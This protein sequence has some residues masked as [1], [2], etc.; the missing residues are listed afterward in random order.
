MAASPV[1]RSPKPCYAPGTPP[2]SSSNKRHRYRHALVIAAVVVVV[3]MIAGAILVTAKW[4]FTTAKL[5]AELASAT[6][7]DVQFRSFRA[8]Y[9]PPGCVMEGVELRQ[10]P[11]PDGPPLLTAAR[12]TIRANYR[13]FLFNRIEVMRLE[14]VHVD[15][16]QRAKNSNSG[17]SSGASNSSS[18]STTV[19]E[20]I[21]DRGV[22]E[23]PRKAG[24]L[25]F[26]V[27]QLT[28]GS[29]VRG[30][31]TSFHVTLENPL[32]P[33]HLA[34]D[35]QFGPW[36]SSNVGA[37]PLSGKYRFTDAQ[38]SSLG[39]IAGTLSSQ[40]SFAGPA[41]AL[42]VQGSTNTPNFEVK[43]A[44]HPVHLRT[45]FQAVVDSTNGDVDLQSVRGEFENTTFA[46]AGPVA[47]KTNPHSKV[48]S[49]QV[50]DA[51]GRVEDWLRLLAPDQTPAMTGPISFQAKVTVPGGPRPFIRRVR[52]V[53]DFE[54]TGVGFT[55]EES[56]HDASE[57]SLRARGDKVPDAKVALP[58]ILGTLSGHVELIDGVANFSTLTFSL[59]GAIAHA[60]GTYS[61]IDEHIDLHGQL[62]A[63][64]KFSKTAGGPKGLVTRATEALFARSKGDGEILP[65]K[66]T[67]T[68]DHPSYGLDK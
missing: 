44:G 64:N 34:V 17:N 24:P 22:I 25:R 40:G 68:Y 11:D 66:M 41:K 47:G 59:P 48:A 46:V 3:V 50:N 12:L 13:G 4:P 52:L 1:A 58:K 15:M 65:V 37:T 31:P 39:G 53:G 27:H 49:L 30:K 38:L 51:A 10:R 28:L 67:G 33:G 56:Q 43:K 18:D 7:G 16:A 54:L 6:S 45:Q 57:L 21:V 14:D 20:L 35:G 26:Q 8:H 29:F 9:F 2:T 36:N 19:A 55:K 42:R 32:P 63:D 5:K 61:F 23:F 60:R 62:R